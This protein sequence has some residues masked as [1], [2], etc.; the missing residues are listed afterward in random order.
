MS[1]EQLMGL[2]VDG[3]ADLWAC[4]VM[5]YELLTGVSPF[6][7]DTPASVMHRVLQL[8]P[9]APSTLDASLTPAL[10]AVVARA[11]AK[12]PEERFQGAREF[13]VALLH[14]LQGKMPGAAQRANPA[15]AAK[16]GALD[17]PPEMLAE[18]ERSLSRH[19]GPLAT[20]LVKRERS[21]SRTLEEFLRKLAENIPDEGE[22]S[23][24]LRKM[25]AVRPNPPAASGLLETI[26]AAPAARAAASPFTSEML[27]QAEKLLASYVGPLARV[28]IKEAASKS[29]NVKELYGQLAA[30]IDSEDERR[31]F[32]A[33]LGR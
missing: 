13:Q 21:A 29:G 32:L 4:G 25:K 30:H 7:A 10:D 17:I 15:P 6:L 18:I 2:T 1:P 26:V 5:L 31:T 22:Q 23:A 20:V 28:L 19:M 14:A 24:F 9:P 33:T 3:R 27:A 11:L 12:K 8:D 16:A